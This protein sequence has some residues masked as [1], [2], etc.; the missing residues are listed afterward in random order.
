[1]YG[2]AALGADAVCGE[3]CPGIW[4][5]FQ[6]MR[7]FCEII[8]NV[9]V[10]N[11]LCHGELLDDAVLKV[12]SQSPFLYSIAR[13]KNRRPGGE[14]RDQAKI[15]QVRVSSGEE[16]VPVR[17]RLLAKQRI[18]QGG[19]PGQGKP[20]ARSFKGPPWSP[21]EAARFHPALAASCQSTSG[22]RTN[23]YSPG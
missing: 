18:R 6:V 4:K 12:F 22:L 3:H 17:S 8:H 16:V 2:I 11:G 14:M 5:D 1:M 19:L 10:V 9:F 23:G 20:G 7:Y 13:E 15:K 21:A